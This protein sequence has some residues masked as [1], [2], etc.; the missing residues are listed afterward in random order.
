MMT[1]ARG[2]QSRGRKRMDCLLFF[3]LF[4]LSGG[5]SSHEPGESG[6]MPLR[7]CGKGGLRGVL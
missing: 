2:V 6:L 4:V 5:M 1:T 7:S 3:F